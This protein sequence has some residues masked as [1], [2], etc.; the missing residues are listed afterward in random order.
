[1]AV[2]RGLIILPHLAEVNHLPGTLIAFNQDVFDL[3]P[4]VGDFRRIGQ[5]AA[6]AP[7]AGRAV[8]GEVVAHLE[9]KIYRM[10]GQ[11]GQIGGETGP[12]Q[13]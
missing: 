12:R 8:H 2:G 9:S 1:M 3:R 11:G 4:L 5:V 10:L 6:A 7:T 13:R